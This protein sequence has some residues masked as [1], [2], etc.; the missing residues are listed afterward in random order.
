MGNPPV[1]KI[2]QNF[3]LIC[4]LFSKIYV[5]TVFTIYPN[6]DL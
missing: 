2:K 6:A 1:S 3:T 4:V 5:S